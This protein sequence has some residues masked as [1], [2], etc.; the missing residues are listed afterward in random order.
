MRK[1]IIAA[2]LLTATAAFAQS[3]PTKAELETAL[4]KCKPH[5][6]NYQTP[7][8]KLDRSKKAVP[9]YEPGWEY[10]QA[11]AVMYGEIV[12]S[13]ARAASPAK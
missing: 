1:F 11:K 7:D 13:E 5:A 9:P 4:A 10:C 2:L 3:T 8:G 6:T 12:N